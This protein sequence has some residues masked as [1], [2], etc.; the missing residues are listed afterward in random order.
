M[1]RN[2][3]NLTRHYV[4][5]PYLADDIL[6]AWAIG[7]QRSEGQVTTNQLPPHG[8][9][10]ISSKTY[11]C[12]EGN[13]DKEPS[14][15]NLRMSTLE[16]SWVARNRH[17]CDTDWTCAA[18]PQYKLDAPSV[19]NY[20]QSSKWEIT[21]IWKYYYSHEKKR[22]S[23]TVWWWLMPQSGELVTICLLPSMIEK[24][25]ERM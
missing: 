11:T 24:Q 7:G 14:K 25:N 16:W 19:R 6:A 20:S 8:T 9:G 15:F 18:R 21:I 10:T 12:C 3:F 2:D 23:A 22:L 17:A 5:I 1:W 13:H 4:N